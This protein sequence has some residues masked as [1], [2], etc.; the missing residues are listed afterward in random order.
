M[1][2]RELDIAKNLKMIDWLKAE[3]IDAVA[4]LFKSLLKSGSEAVSDA[5]ATIIILA[6]LLGQRVGLSFSSIDQ[7]IRS[8]LHISLEDSLGGDEW[9]ENLSE[10]LVYLEKT[11]R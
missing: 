6:Y 1:K 7:R 8:K 5:L 11:K 4:E 3:L 9:Q 10:L 2:N